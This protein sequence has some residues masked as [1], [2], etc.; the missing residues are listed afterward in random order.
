M[1]M[2]MMMTD[3]NRTV[4]ST[5]E[6]CPTETHAR[7]DRKDTPAKISPRKL[8]LLKIANSFLTIQ[9][10]NNFNSRY[11]NILVKFVGTAVSIVKPFTS[12]NPIMG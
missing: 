10:Y 8:I 5:T 11:I 1:Y 6:E 12:K 3:R 4:M 2:K 7:L 9:K